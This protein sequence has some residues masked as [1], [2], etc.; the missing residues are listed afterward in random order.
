M[1]ADRVYLTF[2]D[3]PD[4]EWTPR[5]LDAL[6]QAKVKATF[7]AVGQQAQRL[8]DLVRRVHDAGHAVGNHTFSH[9][10][11]WFMSQQSARAQVRDGA[12]AISDVLGV[13]PRFYR[14]PHGRK[15]ACMSDEAQRCGEQIVLWDVSAVDWGPLGVVD[16]IEKRLNAVKG[17][18]I[19]L[20]H[21]GQNKHNRPDQLLQILPLFL[22]KL[23]DRGLHP[24]L[25]PA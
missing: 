10:H 9:R 4:P 23:A 11:P 7:F 5:V 18:D 2:D 20:M 8:P 3:G 1:S 12:N 21:D 16:S 14:P 24:A 17:G 25:L 22:R 15:R 6:E 13:A 19:V